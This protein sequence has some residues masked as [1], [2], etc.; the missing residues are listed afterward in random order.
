MSC[1]CDYTLLCFRIVLEL[2]A[3][4]GTV[5]TKIPQTR[6]FSMELDLSPFW[7]Q[8]VQDLSAGTFSAHLLSASSDYSKSR[9]GCRRRDGE[10]PQL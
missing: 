9:C 4:L 6:G 8:E 1:Q 3:G 7:R 2:M 10:D 5:Y